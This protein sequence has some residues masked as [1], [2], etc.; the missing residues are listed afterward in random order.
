[1]PWRKRLEAGLRA[2]TEIKVAYS[3]DTNS[4]FAKIPDALVKAMHAHGWKFYTH[5]GG[6]QEA[7]LMCSWDTTTDDVDNFLADLRRFATH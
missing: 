1:M 7:R 6:W 4:V 2:F 5:V 3:V